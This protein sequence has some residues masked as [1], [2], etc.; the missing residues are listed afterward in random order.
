MRSG[1]SRKGGLNTLIQS[2]RG[3]RK[4]RDEG[5]KARDEE[6]GEGRDERDEGANGA[7]CHQLT[8][9]ENQVEL[10][11]ELSLVVEQVPVQFIILH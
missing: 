3:F 7:A 1:H 9:L 5:R 11:D 8:N 10:S 2:S 4:E 6:R